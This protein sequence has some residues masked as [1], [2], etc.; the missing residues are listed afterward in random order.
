MDNV[1]VETQT[2]LVELVFRITPKSNGSNT[3]ESF[4]RDL[5][6][7]ESFFNLQS[8]DFPRKARKWLNSE[9]HALRIETK[10]PFSCIVKEIRKGKNEEKVLKNLFRFL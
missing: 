3:R 10:L 5:G 2:L 6:L 9:R 4:I 1:D 8:D 7:S